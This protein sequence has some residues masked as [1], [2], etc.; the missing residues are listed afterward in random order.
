MEACR[1]AYDTCRPFWTPKRTWYRSLSRAGLWDRLCS[2]PFDWLNRT[3]SRTRP[4]AVASRWTKCQTRHCLALWFW[5]RFGAKEKNLFLLA[6]LPT[7]TNLTHVTPCWMRTSSASSCCLPS[8]EKC[9]TA[10]WTASSWHW[11]ANHLDSS[12]TEHLN[13]GIRW[14]HQSCLEMHQSLVVYDLT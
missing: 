14:P 12:P 1:S 2:P 8:V 9:V 4:A 6:C 10:C 13:A 11:A 5:D 7:H 3:A